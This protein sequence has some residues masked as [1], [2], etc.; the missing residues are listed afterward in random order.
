MQLKVVYKNNNSQPPELQNET[1]DELTQRVF[2]VDRVEDTYATFFDKVYR[3]F[4]GDE[5]PDKKRENFR[6]RAFNTQY[7]IMLDTYTGKEN[8]NMKELKIYPMKTL[9]LEE[10]LDSETFEEYDPE[11]MIIKVN[12]WRPGLEAL[13]KEVLLPIELKVSKDMPMSKLLELVA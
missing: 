4:I 10:K 2:Y 6:L 12:F 7:K 9:A 1:N 8:E 5:S 3:E 11:A 13:T